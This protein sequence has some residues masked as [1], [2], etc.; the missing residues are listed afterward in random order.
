MINHT[1]EPPYDNSGLCGIV[2]VLL[3]RGGTGAIPGGSDGGSTT[4]TASKRWPGTA[5]HAQESRSSWIL[6]AAA[7][8][9]CESDP[10]PRPRDFKCEPTN[11]T[12]SLRQRTELPCQF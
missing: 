6:P 7:T 8:A 12:L 11:P 10:Q 5:Q 9:V 4:T 2:A 3:C 1:A